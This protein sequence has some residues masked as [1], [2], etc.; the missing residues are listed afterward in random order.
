MAQLKITQV[1]ST[2]DRSKRQKATMIALGIRKINQSVV[3]DVNPQL[4]GM[5]A[6]IQHLVK[7]EEC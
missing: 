7:I 3:K 6:K 4:M 5:V 1:K 2:I